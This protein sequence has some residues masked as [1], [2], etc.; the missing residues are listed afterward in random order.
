MDRFLEDVAERAWGEQS[1]LR[2]RTHGGGQEEVQGRGHGKD[3][4][5]NKERSETR[6]P[7]TRRG[8]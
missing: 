5:A 2:L 3:K 7:K 4:E 6:P 1:D 8:Q